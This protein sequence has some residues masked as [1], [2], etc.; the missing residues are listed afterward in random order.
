M[1]K[2]QPEQRDSVTSLSSCCNGEKGFQKFP[3]SFA[4]KREPEASETT[5]EKGCVEAAL[6]QIK[7]KEGSGEGTVG[8]IEA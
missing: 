1:K 7:E 2:C 4:H 3:D 8:F 6:A 5:R